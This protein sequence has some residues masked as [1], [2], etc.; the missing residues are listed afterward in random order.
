MEKIQ[1][2]NSY[3]DLRKGDIVVFKNGE[4]K[5]ILSIKDEHKAVFTDGEMR[6][7]WTNE[8]KIEG[9]IYKN[10]EER[11][12]IAKPYVCETKE[13]GLRFESLATSYDELYNMLQRHSDGPVEFY[14]F[15][16][17]QNAVSIISTGY[18]YS[19]YYG[20]IL[21]KYDND[22]MNETSNSVMG[23]NYSPILQRY[24]RFYL[25]IRNKATCSMYHN[26]I[27]NNT[28]GVIIA[29]DYDSIWKS[30]T[31][32]ILYPVNGHFMYDG[33]FYW[34][35]FNIGYQGNLKNLNRFNFN[36]AKT[37]DAYDAYEDNPYLAAEI[38]FHNKVSAEIIKHI[39]F[40]SEDELDNFINC[41]PYNKREQIRRKCEVR[42]ELF[43][44]KNDDN[45]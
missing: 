13:T 28:Y 7:F 11:S 41:L 10:I 34:G 3:K 29:L 26:F 23:S 25:N 5:T 39:Y 2:Y 37:Y 44:H 17:V 14:H 33:D 18:L 42:W 36:F 32:V 6:D 24:A 12:V 30:G 31:N 45:Y 15:T 4:R 27:K 40:E 19:R 20:G 38:L 9:V 35:R 1:K 43:W 16:A 8:D 21:I 22:K